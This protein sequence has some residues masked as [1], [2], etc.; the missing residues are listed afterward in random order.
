MVWKG[1]ALIWNKSCT[2]ILNHNQVL[3]AGSISEFPLPLVE[4]LLYKVYN[5]PALSYNR[6]RSWDCLEAI[7][8]PSCESTESFLRAM[9]LWPACAGVSAGEA[10]PATHAK[11]ERGLTHALLGA[12][13]TRLL[14]VGRSLLYLRALTC[15]GEEDGVGRDYTDTWVGVWVWEIV[16]ADRMT[17]LGTFL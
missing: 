8:L 6:Q 15:V 10:V 3:S 7:L 5:F 4:R 13:W 2:K 11:C 14:L 17:W 9:L 1:N 16:T 12:C